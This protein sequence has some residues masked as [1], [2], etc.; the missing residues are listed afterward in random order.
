METE[1]RSKMIYAIIAMTAL[2]LVV[3]SSCRQTPIEDVIVQLD[4]H[5]LHAKVFG[6]GIP[7]VVVD[8]GLGGTI[9]EW[10]D[11]QN[12]LS[13]R[14]TV[15]LYNR[16]GY[17]T[18][19]PGPFP[20][21]SRREMMELKEM[22]L[23]AKILGPYIIVGH[24]L[25]ALNAQVFADE[26][27]SEVKGIV[28]LDPP[29]ISWLLGEDFLELLDMANRMTDEWKTASQKLI[30]S[31]NPKGRAQGLF[32][33][34]IASEQLEMTGSSAR[35]VAEIQSYG[36]MPLVVIA[37]EVPNPMFGEV[38][39]EYQKYWIESSREL[40]HKSSEGK[41]ILAEGCTH[42]L[43]EEAFDTVIASVVEILER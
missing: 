22:L 12:R 13:E 10:F 17:G 31:D 39:E 28:L 41:F 25:G 35:M 26:Y 42:R 36:N 29:P 23:R 11:F 24:S 27:S 2:C 37:S 18:S 20:R 15:V 9:D 38:A 40:A 5:S 30:N 21:D 7:T 1:S 33:R 34:T 19:E 4:T 16:A 3:I 43:H 32:L 8:V 6:S 14:T